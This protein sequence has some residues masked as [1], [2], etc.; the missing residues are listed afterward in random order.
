MATTETTACGVDRGSQAGIDR[1]KA[2]GELLCRDCRQA[3]RAVAQERARKKMSANPV[4]VDDF[5]DRARRLMK[6]HSLGLGGL[7]RGMRMHYQTLQTL[8]KGNSTPRKATITRA[9]E[10]L[11]R[12]ERELAA[13]APEALMAGERAAKV[14][15]DHNRRAYE[16]W[17]QRREAR[18]RVRGEPS[19]E[20]VGS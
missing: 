14:R 3:A 10:C 12:M 5:R 18:M 4:E 2:T 15:E 7:A 19:Q 8:L 20:L 9:L 1:H 13:A 17:R 11:G 16:K 6:D